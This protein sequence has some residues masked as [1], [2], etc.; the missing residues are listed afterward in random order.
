ML[1]KYSMYTSLLQLVCNLVICLVHKYDHNVSMQTSDGNFLLF[2][3]GQ[4]FSCILFAVIP[5]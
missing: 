5:P 2:C 1:C 3:R 4:G